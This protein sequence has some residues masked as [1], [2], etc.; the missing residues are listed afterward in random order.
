[1]PGL[2]SPTGET[3]SDLHSQ[4]PQLRNVWH[5][6]SAPEK[7]QI[8]INEQWLTQE[9]NAR[10]LISNCYLRPGCRKLTPEWGAASGSFAGTEEIETVDLTPHCDH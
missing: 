10:S 7:V 2:A 1:M 5:W 8:V 6:L 4:G 3:C 9:D